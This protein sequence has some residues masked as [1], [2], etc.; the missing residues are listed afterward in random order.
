MALP[1]EASNHHTVWVSDRG[2]RPIAVRYAVAD[3][4]M[5]CFG[6]DGLRTVPDG[7]RVR[8]SIH[9]IAGGAELASFHPMMY[10][11]EPEEV[12]LEALLGL[13]EHVS[14][15]STLRE[16]QRSLATHRNRRIVRLQP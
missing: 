3:G 12:P 14:L 6:D 1:A 8:A 4:R 5:Y 16:V 9:E 2:H 10:R 11:V 13:L 15:G 7:S